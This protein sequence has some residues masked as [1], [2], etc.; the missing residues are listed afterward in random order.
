MEN[1]LLAYVKIVCG[2]LNKNTVE[3]LIVGGTAVAF[4]GYS[5]VS[6]TNNGQPLGKYDLD[7]WYNPNYSNY[8]KL[9]NALVELG[10]DISGIKNDSPNPK[11]SF[12]RYD[13]EE[14]KIDFLPEIK[15]LNN[16]NTSYSKSVHRNIQG[17]DIYFISIDD[18]I[19]SKEVDSRPKDIEDIVK[20]KQKRTASEEE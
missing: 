9:L 11:T 14:F 8:Y 6:K 2:V 16:F 18:L 10:V 5:R 12:F 20:L 19:V 7:F 1:N 17:V 3:Y 4:Y 13:F 15:G